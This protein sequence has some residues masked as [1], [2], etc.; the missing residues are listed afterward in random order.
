MELLTSGGAVEQFE[1]SRTLRRSSSS[2]FHPSQTDSES[3]HTQP[4]T[5]ALVRLSTNQLLNNRA[6]VTMSSCSPTGSKHGSGSCRTSGQWDSSVP[7]VAFHPAASSPHLLSCSDK[8][9]LA[10]LHQQVAHRER[11]SANGLL[12]QRIQLTALRRLIATRGHLSTS[13][14]VI[15]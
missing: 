7:P 4:L 15:T 1:P 9:L 14:F 11:F 6:A 12:L 3:T 10:A 13:S 5:P 2:W 8:R